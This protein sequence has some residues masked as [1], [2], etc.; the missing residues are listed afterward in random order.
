MFQCQRILHNHRF[1]F[2]NLAV[3]F[4]IHSHNIICSKMDYWIICLDPLV[5]KNKQNEKDILIYL[6][7]NFAISHTN[8]EYWT[9]AFGKCI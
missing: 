5:R 2:H 1:K 7:G 4:F 3:M 8:S 9:P 6:R